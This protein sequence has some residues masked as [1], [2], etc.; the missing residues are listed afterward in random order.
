MLNYSNYEKLVSNGLATKNTKEIK[1][2]LIHSFVYSFTVSYTDYLENILLLETRGHSFVEY[3]GII[4]P[5]CVPFNKFFNAYENP[6]TEESV[7]S[8]LTPISITEKNDGSLIMVGKLPNGELLAK[9]KSTPLSEQGIR[10]TEIIN[11]KDSYKDFCNLWIDSGYTVLLEYVAPTNQI[12]LFYPEEKLVLL[13]LRNMI[14]GEYFN[15][16]DL[17]YCPFE[18]VQ[19]YDMTIEDIA[20][21]QES[22]KNREGFVVLYGP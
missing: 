12:V 22:S 1:N 8:K 17:G 7:L 6:F 11:S 20:K 16:K 13:A 15:L 4:E 14:T 2:Y 19:S 5:F 21:I 10:A 18:V 9:T 3:K